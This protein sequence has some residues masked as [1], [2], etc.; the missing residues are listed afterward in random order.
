MFVKAISGIPFSITAHGQDF[1]GDLGSDQLLRELCAAAE[2]VGAETDYSRDMLAA[3]CPESRDKIFRVYNG[4]DLSRFPVSETTRHS[5]DAIRFL[6]TGR[7]VPF[8]GFDILIDA[9]AQLQNRGLHFACEIIGDGPLHRELEE[10]VV[11]QNL[12]ER[13]HLAGEQSQDYVLR[14]LRNSD[15]FVLASTVDERGASD[16]FPTVIAEAMASSRPVVST[17]VAGIPELVANGETG[18]L[19]PRDNAGALADAME[20]LAR[21]KRLRGSFGR[22]G[23]VR[24]KQEFTIEQTIEP[25]LARF[26]HLR[27]QSDQ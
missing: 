27:L 2:F 23:R 9:C 13:I 14:A 18:L 20:Q 25:L 16:I 5:S 15:I 26:E 21:D 10:R 12:R 7:L 3:R 1:M 24:I 17:T 11:K 19:V 4:I 6:S 22:A 8:K